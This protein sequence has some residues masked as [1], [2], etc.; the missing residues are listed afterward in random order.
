[1]L[2]KSI[3]G[4]G[5][6]GNAISKMKENATA[7]ERKELSNNAKNLT[8]NSKYGGRYGQHQ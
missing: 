1:M 7:E 3:T 6:L 5:A 2:T 4:G 8:P